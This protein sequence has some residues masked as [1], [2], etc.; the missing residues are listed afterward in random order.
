MK[1]LRILVVDEFPIVEEGLEHFLQEYPDIQIVATAGSCMG[2]LTALRQHAIDIVVQDLSS[3]ELGGAEAIRLFLEKKP[4]VGI[5]VYSGRDDEVTVFEALK[6]GAKGYILKSVPITELVDAIREVAQGRYALS[7]SLNPS[8]IQFY[9]K[10]RAQAA[11]QLS[12]YQLLTNR[13]KQVFRLL[14]AGNLT[15][16]IGDILCISPKTVAKHRAA[17]KKKLDLN[18]SAKMV[19]YAIR[20]GVIN[21]EHP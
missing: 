4:Q 9:L 18:T 6:A 14:A 1:K 11:D 17:V 21:V 8:I 12:A 16:D 3:T 5:I 15:K 2:G 10:H 20:L 13:E 19:K 7:P